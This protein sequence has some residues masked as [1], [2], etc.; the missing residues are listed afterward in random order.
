[1]GQTLKRI[2]NGWDKHWFGQ[3]LNWEK[4]QFGQ[5]GGTSIKR[6]KQQTLRGTNIE[7]DKH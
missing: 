5:T 6:Y 1:M 2:N 7:R 3:S 4:H